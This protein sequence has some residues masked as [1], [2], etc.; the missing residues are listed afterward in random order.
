MTPAHAEA[1]KN[2]KNA[3][4]ETN[5]KSKNQ[6]LPIIIK[7]PNFGGFCYVKASWI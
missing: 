2:I 4:A 6:T 5:N 7:P 3:A 1:A